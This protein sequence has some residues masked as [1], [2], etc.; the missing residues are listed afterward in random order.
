[1]DFTTILSHIMNA[2]VGVYLPDLTLPKSK[3]NILLKLYWKQIDLPVALALIFWRL[4]AFQRGTCIMCHAVHSDFTQK[5]NRYAVKQGR[6]QN[7]IQQGIEN[8]W[9]YFNI[10][11]NYV[12]QFKLPPRS[13]TWSKTDGCSSPPWQQRAA[14]LSQR[15]RNPFQEEIKALL[16]VYTDRLDTISIFNEAE[17]SSVRFTRTTEKLLY[18]ICELTLKSYSYSTMSKIASAC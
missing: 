3:M 13:S 15:S 11:S 18:E 1:M 14:L 10:F 8:R 7:H 2:L 16:F 4:F 9:E 17:T 6:T 12:S 5:H